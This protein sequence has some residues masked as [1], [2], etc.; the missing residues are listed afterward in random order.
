MKTATLDKNPTDALPVSFFNGLFS[1]S[2]STYISKT[3]EIKLSNRLGQFH[4]KIFVWLLS[5]HSKVSCIGNLQV[6]TTINRILTD[7]AI[8]NNSANYEKCKTALFEIFETTLIIKSSAFTTYVKLISKITI[9]ENKFIIT[10][11]KDVVNIFT[12]HLRD[13][14]YNLFLTSKTGLQS[15]LNGFLSINELNFKLPLSYFFKTLNCEI[16]TIKAYK[17]AF[18]TALIR[19]R[20]A[21]LLSKYYFDETGF[22]QIYK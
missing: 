1:N 4:L 17:R 19:A 13:I 21:G 11:D 3:E 16:E 9:A 15:A 14:D 22:V 20:H 8:S 7:C 10:L 5:Q 12:T 18:E 6:A 2:T